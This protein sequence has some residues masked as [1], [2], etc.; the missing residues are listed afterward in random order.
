MH[1]RALRNP[2]VWR[3][4]ALLALGL[5]LSPVLGCH[6]ADE[7][8]GGKG[9]GRGPRGGADEADGDVED[10]TIVVQADKSRILQEEAALQ[11]R[12][13]DFETEKARIERQRSDI[14]EKLA[15]ISKTDRTQRDKLEQ[16][17]QRLTT[18]QRQL[19]ER[20]ASFDGERTKLDQE[21]TL[22]LERI[23]SLTQQQAPKGGLTPEQKEEGVVRRERDVAVREKE[24]ARREAEAARGLTNVELLL[25]EVRAALA[26]NKTVVEQTVSSMMPQVARP[27]VSTVSRAQVLRQQRQVHINL[28]N[29]GVLLEDLPAPMRDL[30]STANA[31]LQNKD[32]AAAQESLSTLSQALDA[33]PINH[34]FVQAKMARINRQF[35]D[36]KLGKNMD[37]PRQ[38]KI[39]GLLGEASDSFSD[40]RYDRANKKI[41]QIYT[42]LQNR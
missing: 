2:I 34:A 12:R 37:E 32:Y 23:A 17:E 4:T 10:L 33:T 11:V 29:K 3:R 26:A 40:G 9:G 30:E 21:K 13:N 16:A 19:R 20:A 42:L 18:E 14:S 25:G 35:S 15:S 36:K 6:R 7:G 27:A 28:N 8:H 31:A 24:V 41:N 5:L 22:L 1:T 39:M 38:R